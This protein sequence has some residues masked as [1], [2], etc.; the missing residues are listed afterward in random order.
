MTAFYTETCKRLRSEGISNEYIAGWAAGFLHNPDREEQTST[1]A[2][3][4]GYE[5]GHEG[6]TEHA[7]EFHS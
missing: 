5:D 3:Q 4:A 2:F 7:P 1:D 6:N